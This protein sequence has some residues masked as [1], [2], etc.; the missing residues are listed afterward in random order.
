MSNRL[1]STLDIMFQFFMMSPVS[2]ETCIIFIVT[3]GIR[4]C[5]LYVS[6]R[7]PPTPEQKKVT[8]REWLSEGLYEGE[9]QSLDEVR[10]SLV[11][12]IE[13]AEEID[14]VHFDSYHHKSELP[15]WL[16]RAVSVGCR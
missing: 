2:V 1:K 6:P 16:A 3:S 14:E 9:V 4:M 5:R 13:A 11:K 12:D 7:Y 10:R 15:L 8:P